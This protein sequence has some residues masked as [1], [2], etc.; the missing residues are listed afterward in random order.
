M[1]NNAL[2]SGADI[3]IVGCAITVLKDIGHAADG[4]LEPIN[5]KEIDPFR[6]MT[7]FFSQHN[8]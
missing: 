8:G 2:K 1:Q 5:K 3:L 4:Y 7:A 6:I